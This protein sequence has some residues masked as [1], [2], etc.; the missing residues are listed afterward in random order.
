M[1]GKEQDRTQKMAKNFETQGSGRINS[2]MEGTTLQGEIRTDSNM[3]IDGKVKG[4]I[5]AKGKII[6]GQ[7]G[8]VEGEVVCQTSEIEGALEG[9]ITC[10]EILSLKATA[11]LTGDI[12]TKKLAI[13]PGAAFS[14]N[15]SMGAVVKDMKQ[16]EASAA[17]EQMPPRSEERVAR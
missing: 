7:T 4:T 14:G 1:F 17:K 3:R 13:E 16:P 10:S 6:I 12:L 5:H 8:V 2:I 15:C 9:K 11:K